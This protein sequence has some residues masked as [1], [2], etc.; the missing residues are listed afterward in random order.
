MTAGPRV[1][2]IINPAAGAAEPVLSVLNDVL[3]GAGVDW[4]VAITHGPGDA[5]AAAAAAADEGYDFVASYGGDGTLHEV[6][7]GLAASSGPPVLILPGGTG[8]AVAD[9]LGIPPTL[10]AATALV[11]GAHELRPLDLGRIENRYFA[12][13]VTMG[14]EADMV[15]G[16]T[17]D[18]KAKLG[19]FAYAVSGLRA[20]TAEPVAHYT[21]EVDGRTFEE[22]GLALLIANSAN[23]G[24]AGVSLATG[25]DVSDGLLDVVVIRPADL[26]GF[27]GSAV[28]AVQGQE[29]RALCHWQGTSIKV[30]AEPPQAVL[31]D[32]EEAG[33]TPV[34]VGVAPS[35][36]RVVVPA[37]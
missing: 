30:H 5:Q 27:L 17:P 28:D 23:T 15:T 13:R 22:D 9:D 25:V 6:V 4:D 35:A 12:L 1:K 37:K 33:M 14:L 16:T 34:E 29:P 2:V 18:M 32:G 10:S 36:V 20:L 3:G 26:P 21:I 11:T 7:T 8:N 24:V 31:C 19:W